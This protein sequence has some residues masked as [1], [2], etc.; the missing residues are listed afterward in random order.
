M[1]DTGGL[2]M[3]GKGMARRGHGVKQVLLIRTDAGMNAGKT[4]AQ[5]SHASM[6]AFLPRETTQLVPLSDGQ[7]ELRAIISAQAAAWFQDL[8]V[9]IALAG[10]DESTLHDVYRQAREAGL[11]CVLIQDAGFTHFDGVPTYTAVGI[12][13]AD[14]DDIDKITRQFPLLR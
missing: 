2:I 11:P 9:K 10:P 3:A 14:A 8:S 12:G 4:A 6:G 7:F 13:P 1:C 5:A